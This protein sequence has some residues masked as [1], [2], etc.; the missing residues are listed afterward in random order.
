MKKIFVLLTAL[1][2]WYNNSS[3]QIV[4]PE[5]ARIV[6]MNFYAERISAATDDDIFIFASEPIT[7]SDNGLPAIYVFETTD[8]PGFIMVAADY[9]VYPV[10]GYSF[11]SYF[12][13]PSVPPVFAD[14]INDFKDQI[15]MAR[16]LKQQASEAATQD[17]N[18]YSDPMFTKSAKNIRAQL[19]LLQ[20]RWDQGCF[21]NALCPEDLDGPCGY[22]WAG[23][24]ATAMAQV[25]KYHN[26]PPSGDGSN[27]YL[28][29]NGYGTLNVDFSQQTYSW[30]VMENQLFDHNFEVAKLIYH[31]GVAVN[32]NYAPD[33]SGAQTS[34]SADV[35]KENFKYADYVIHM[36]KDYFSE[37]NWAEMICIELL[38]H[39]PLMYRGYGS[40]GHAFVCDGFQ[41]VNSN[42]FHFDFGWSGAANGYYYLSN[43]NGFTSDQAGI[44]GM[45][46]KYTGP[47]YCE[48]YV[49]LTDPQGT[50]SDGSDDGRYANNSSCKWLIQPDNAG[51]IALTFTQLKTEPGF[52]RVLIY[53]G[54]SENDWLVADISG[55]DLPANPVV[56]SGGSMF[57]WFITDELNAAPGWEA[58]YTTWFTDV[59]DYTR[60]EITVSPNPAADIVYVQLA[61]ELND[62]LIVIIS[63]LSGRKVSEW[64]IIPQ[65]G[66]FSLDVSTLAKGVYTIEAFN[67]NHSIAK[68]KMIVNN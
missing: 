54:T 32:M 19:P 45:E 51:A 57:M 1:I 2:V 13:E 42:H 63:D 56:V 10:L 68:E 29:P 15:S 18:Y 6:A 47:S 40:G 28:T 35:F 60:G 46:P 66:Y 16:T 17:W 44:F 23:C 31:C 20:T 7:I 67:G 64:N 3:A 38:S 49:L 4:E 25:M 50:I 62:P 36:E 43:L 30:S 22:V 39:R 52:D 53:E 11:E 34:T 12:N 37:D 27:I 26:W 9:S 21:Y 61:T 8:R 48:D 41:G 65:N 59:E 24:V 55:F 14:M 33:G 58:N 5:E